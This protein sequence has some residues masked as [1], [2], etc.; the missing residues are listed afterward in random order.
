MKILNKIWSYFLD[1]LYFMQK[2]LH[3]K[4]IWKYIFKLIQEK[5]HRLNMYTQDQLLFK[6]FYKND[7][8]EITPIE[9]Y[10]L[11]DMV[12]KYFIYNNKK[13]PEFGKIFTSYDLNR[14]IS[15][16]NILPSN[17]LIT[18]TVKNII[19]ELSR[20]EIE[21]ENIKEEILKTHQTKIILDLDN[22]IETYI[23]KKNYEYI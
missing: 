1:E 21:K 8:Y 12:E 16:Y 2:E 13:F 15:N 23:N 17:L 22:L 14:Y 18:D 4:R 5:E 7:F 3:R 9:H 11:Y 19:N 6:P 20:K 10:E